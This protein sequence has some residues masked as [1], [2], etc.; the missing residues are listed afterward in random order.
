MP[1]QHKRPNPAIMAVAVLLFLPLTLAACGARDTIVHER[2]G[3]AIVLT[4]GQLVDSGPTVIDALS[5]AVANLTVQRR[6]GR[7]PEITIRGAKTIYGQR[8]PVV[9]LDGTRLGDTCVLSQLSTRD[10]ERIE[11]YASGASP[12]PRYGAGTSGLILVFSAH[13]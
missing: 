6:D 7:C 2:R 9:Y 8:G 11:V 5:S 3:S 10:I 4:G 1:H 13:R 12:D